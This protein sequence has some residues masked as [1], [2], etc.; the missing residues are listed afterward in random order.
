MCMHVHVHVVA[1]G[2]G[3]LCCDW[4]QWSGCGQVILSHEASNVSSL[5]E[6]RKGKECKDRWRERELCRVM[7][8]EVLTAL[9]TGH[10][11]G[12]GG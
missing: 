1:I 10:Q 9:A 5:G 11:E 4:L 12:M 2:I 7:S 6:Q 8:W 3:K